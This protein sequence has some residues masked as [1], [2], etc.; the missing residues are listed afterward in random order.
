MFDINF[1]NNLVSI[2]FRIDRHSYILTLAKDLLIAGMLT[3][4]YINE[5]LISKGHQRSSSPDALR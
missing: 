2:S 5:T 1:V 3:N 4:R